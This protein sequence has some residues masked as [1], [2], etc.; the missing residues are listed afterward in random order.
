MEPVSDSSTKL[1]SGD[2]T[3]SEEHVLFLFNMITEERYYRLLIVPV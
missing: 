1:P 3:F 2:P